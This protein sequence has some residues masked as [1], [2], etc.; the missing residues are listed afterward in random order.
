M[1]GEMA[2]RPERRYAG[3]LRVMTPR[4]RWLLLALALVGL[5]FATTSSWVH[6]RLL[7]DPSY[8][9]PCDVDATFNCTQAYLSRYGSLW[10]VPVAIGG[11]AWFACVALVSAFVRPAADGAPGPAGSYVFLLSAIG[12]ASVLRLA[13]ASYVLLK[14]VCLLCLGTYVCVLGI[15]V[16]SWRAASV[17][18][19]RLPRRL[20]GDLRS[21]AARPIVLTM[22]ALY[23]GGMGSAVAFFPR[24]MQV[25][26]TVPEPPAQDEQARFASAWAQQPRVD[27]GIPADGAK[28]V[29]V[30]FND[31]MCPTCKVYHY[32]YAPVLEQ[33]ATSQPGA[34]RYVVRDFPLNPGC[35]PVVLRVVGGHESSCEAAGAVRM[36]RARGKADAM[37]DWLFSNQE[38]INSL[39]ERRG[40]GAEAIKAEVQTMLGITDFDGELAALLP[41]IRKE[42]EEGGKVTIPTTPTYFVNGV[43]TTVTERGAAFGQNLPPEY[44]DMAIKIELGRSSGGPV[45][46][47]R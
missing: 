29:V 5:G 12:L 7:T 45:V 16:V 19:S 47:R 40:G 21:L 36:A 4:T 37:I 14:V 44:L 23:V 24:E 1:W 22:V 42:A 17:P 32:V 26:T 35:N 27:L 46:N 11:V 31:W 8:V 2:L 30:K 41:A 15:F 9:S 33:Y 25:R 20:A 39:N 3:G 10:G 6:Y 38:R 43:R 13:Y 34:V 28:V 18:I